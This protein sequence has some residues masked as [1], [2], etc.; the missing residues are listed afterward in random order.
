MI[1]SILVLMYV[2]HWHDVPKFCD[3]YNNVLI[4]SPTHV[5][6]CVVNFFAPIFSVRNVITQDDDR[7]VVASLIC[8]NWIMNRENGIYQLFAGSIEAVSTTPGVSSYATN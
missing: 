5:W 3:I 2:F 1:I 6:N 4:I 7:E 8:Q